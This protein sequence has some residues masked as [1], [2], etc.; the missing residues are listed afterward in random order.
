MW[1]LRAGAA[2]RVEVELPLAPLVRR[3]TRL[4]LELPVAQELSIQV[5][6]ADGEPVPFAAVLLRA[7][8]RRPPGPRQV[9]APRPRVTRRTPESS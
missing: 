6:A 5:V 7:D 8:A 9:A 1:A 2:G 3:Q 4:S